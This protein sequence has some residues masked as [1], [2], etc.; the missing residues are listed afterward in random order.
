MST[1]KDAAREIV[2]NLPDQA[3]WDDLMYEVYARQKI[4]QGMADI[5]AGRTV[6]HGQV[7]AEVL[8]DGD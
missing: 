2:E 7:K 1:V 6:P 5:E 8:G 4:E 3:T